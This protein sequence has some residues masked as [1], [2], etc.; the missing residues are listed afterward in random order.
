M[1]SKDKEISVSP[2]R[3]ASLFLTLFR[4]WI[5]A[6]FVGMP[7]GFLAAG[8][9]LAFVAF[10][11]LPLIKEKGHVWATLILVVLGFLSAYCAN[12]VII[13]KYKRVGVSAT[14][15]DLALQ[16]LGPNG[17]VF[18]DFLLV[19][20]QAGFCVSY[21]IFIERNLVSIFPTASATVLSVGLQLSLGVLVL[22]THDATRLSL[23][24]TVS[25]FLVFAGL[26][27]CVPLLSF[28]LSTE[29]A[30]SRLSGVP[31]VLG[32]A[33][34]AMTVRRKRSF[35]FFIIFWFSGDRNCAASGIG[36][37]RLI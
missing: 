21:V 19:F 2:L 29:V 28:N 30:A 5:G 24:A 23:M 9:Q 33:C 31:L 20:C 35:C 10:F 32:M 12:L 14:F 34:S 8:K 22:L 7:F 37:V 11:S 6:S 26:S 15:A 27:L 16:V 36:A 1:A 4:G 3:I 25:S 18:L 13:C 17:A